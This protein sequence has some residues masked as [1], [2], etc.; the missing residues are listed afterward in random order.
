M[1]LAQPAIT[2]SAHVLEFINVY[3]MQIQSKSGVFKPR[4]LMSLHASIALN[5]ESTCY[6]PAS[7]YL[8][9]SAAMTEEFNMLLFK[10]TH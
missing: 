5:F 2:T 9:W 10:M 6:S 1:S 4:T 8:E 3:S 7:K